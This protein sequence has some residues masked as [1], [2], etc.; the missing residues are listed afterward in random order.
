MPVVNIQEFNLVSI[1]VDCFDECFRFY[2]EILG[3]KKTREM[4]TGVLLQ[5]GDT[6]CV[7]LEG[8]Y[9]PVTHGKELTETCTCICVSTLEGLKKSY[10]ELKS[11]GVK[12]LGEYAEFSKDF[13]MFRIQDPSGNILEFAGRP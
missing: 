7:Y 5:V 13:H 4:G 9:K 1:Y 3:F 11:A 6:L 2:T 8:G 12:I 10:E